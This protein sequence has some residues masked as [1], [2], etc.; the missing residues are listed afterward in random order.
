VSAGCSVCGA[1]TPA[2][3]PSSQCAHCGSVTWLA[4]GDGRIQLGVR[5]DGTRGDKP[6]NALLPIAHGEAMLRADAAR[7]T[8]GRSGSSL[9]GATGVGCAAAFAA[10]LL[11]GLCIWM[12]VHFGHC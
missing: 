4:R 11:L 6:F 8:S 9:L 12:A 5:V 2:T 1:A 7:G 10:A 3:D